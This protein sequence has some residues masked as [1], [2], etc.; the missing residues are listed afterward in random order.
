MMKRLGAD[1]TRDSIP[2]SLTVFALPILISSIFQQLYTAVDTL[3]VGRV[4][5]EAALA[6]I[7]STAIVY[8]AVLAFALGMGTGMSIVAAR[9]F[10]AGNE[11]RLKKAAAGAIVIGTGTAAAL[12][13]AALL[14]LRPLLT[15]MGTP[16]EAL[17]AGYGY[18]SVI[19]GFMVVTFVYNLCSGMLRAVGDSFTPLVILMIASL[20]NIVLDVLFVGRMNMGLPGAAYATVIAQGVSALLCI[21][22]ILRRGRI[23]VP[24]RRHFVPERRLYRELAGQGL[25]IGAMNAIVFSS[26]LALQRAINDLGYL[27]V[28]AHTAAR[29]INGFLLVPCDTVGAALGTFSA[30]NRG[31]DKRERIVKGLHIGFGAA[32][33]WAA[34]ATAVTAPAAPAMARFVT[35][36]EEA[37]VIGCIADYL[38]FNAPFYAVLC[39][40][41]VSRN[42]LQSLGSKVIPVVMSA[43]E[44]AAKF[45][46]AAAVIPRAGYRGVIVCEPVIWCVMTAV[47]I[48][49]LLRHPYLKKK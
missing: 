27:T 15:A 8:D 28:A 25:S 44:L 1:M 11:E 4:L 42:T 49:A 48:V 46:F 18:I 10:G 19:T 2:K 13:V 3:V 31:A 43:F 17:E 29:R 39:I 30:Q 22:Y 20:L 37:V 47:F 35:G 21:I 38:R 6:A 14:L 41:L 33:V 32:V 5:G 9:C 16:P 24:E 45:F 12:T 23:L 40:L 34:V 7:G 36:S 26:A